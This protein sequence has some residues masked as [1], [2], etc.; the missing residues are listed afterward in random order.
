[1]ADD[2]SQQSDI[3]MSSDS[4]CQGN[5]AI[6]ITKTSIEITIHYASKVHAPKNMILPIFLRET[7]EFFTKIL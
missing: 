6:I 2:H 7:H 3:S 4:Q 1:M 5:F